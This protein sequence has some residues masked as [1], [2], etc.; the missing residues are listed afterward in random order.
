MADKNAAMAGKIRRGAI[1]IGLEVLQGLNTGSVAQPSEEEVPK[2]VRELRNNPYINREGIPLAMDIFEP[3]GKEYEGR[4]L[5]VIVAIHGGGLITG[6]RKISLNLSRELASRGYLVFAIEYRLAP[7]A[8]VCE[9]L[10]DVCA[11]LDLV[12]KKLVEYDVDY[13]RIFLTADSAGAFLAIYTAA[14]KNSV[15][16]QKV[17]GHEPSRMVFKALGISC[18]M[19]YTNR[20]DILGALLSEQFYGDRKDDPNF[21]QYMNPEH[22]EIVN[23]LPPTFLVTSRGDFLNQYTISFNKALKRA[24]KTSKML[25]YSE[26]Y[27]MHTFNFAHPDLEQSIDAN[28][29]MLEFFEK[30][31]AIYA[32]RQLNSVQQE[33]DFKALKKQMETGKLGKIKL[34]KAIRTVNSFGDD[35]LDAP[36]LKSN[37]KAVSYRQMFRKWDNYAE[38]FSAIGL[39]GKNKARVAI[40]GAMTTEAIYSF[41][42]LNMTGAVVSLCPYQILGYPEQLATLIQNEKITDVILTDYAT[43]PSYAK[44]LVDNKDKL[45]LRNIIVLESKLEEKEIAEA[46]L[47]LM[48]NNVKLLKKVQ[49]ISFMSEL[50]QKYEATPIVTSD[51]T[52]EPTVIFHEVND[53]EDK[54]KVVELSDDQINKIIY[55]LG[56]LY[57]KDGRTAI[58]ALSC[59]LYAR[60]AMI[61]QLQ[62]TFFLGNQLVI[63]HMAGY[64]KK[65][66]KNVCRNHVNYL[67][68]RRID[69]ERI[70]NY[71]KGHKMNA[72]SLDV[73]YLFTEKMEKEKMAALQAFFAKHGAHP[74]I[75]VLNNYLMKAVG[76]RTKSDKDLFSIGPVKQMQAPRMVPMVRPMAAPAVNNPLIWKDI[77]GN[78]HDMNKILQKIGIIVMNIIGQAGQKKNAKPA[79]ADVNPEEESK[80][81]LMA[82]LAVLF[83]PSKTDYYYED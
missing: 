45:G 5:P 20:D 13:S 39:T 27:L 6:D 67:F 12:G 79:A 57:A 38:V 75:V 78:V 23:N 41:Y 32:E 63:T 81:Q 26:D 62:L 9:Q 36:A 68:L 77:N 40:P 54:Y 71:A 22:P 48:K 51:N 18:G 59:D 30:E 31:A 64:N 61:N 24:G 49:G 21:I 42:A 76:R 10:D 43:P 3:S 14:M 44:Y 53:T 52:D 73:V 72:S 16:L 69:I 83:E 65:F 56:S 66:F 25:Y 33:K 37:D 1:R 74:Q 17:I 34:H 80:K 50:I 8:N 70:V 82:M 55:E 2:N 29:K 19:F 46:N 47:N 4:E 35:R 15:K 11:G 60:A 7:R 58:T 28:N